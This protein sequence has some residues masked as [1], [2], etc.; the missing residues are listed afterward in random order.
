MKE[1]FTI[2]LLV[3]SQSSF[4]KLPDVI[5]YYY[6]SYL[7]ARDIFTV[8]HLINKKMKEKLKKIKLP[9]EWYPIAFNYH[10]SINCVHC[11]FGFFQLI[12]YSAILNLSLSLLFQELDNVDPNVL[13]QK[14]LNLQGKKNILL[15]IMNRTHSPSKI[16]YFNQ[17]RQNITEL[18]AQYKHKYLEIKEYNFYYLQLPDNDLPFFAQ[19]LIKNVTTLMPVEYFEILR[20]ILFYFKEKVIDKFLENSINSSKFISEKLRYLKIYFEILC[21]NTN[22][23]STINFIFDTYYS[24]SINLNQGKFNP[25]STSEKFDSFLEVYIPKIVNKLELGVII[26]NLDFLIACR[27]TICSLKKEEME[28]LI[29]KLLHHAIRNKRHAIFEFLLTIFT[30]PPEQFYLNKF[31][32]PLIERAINLRCYY[33]TM[34]IFTVVG[35]SNYQKFDNVSLL[36]CTQQQYIKSEDLIFPILFSILNI[37]MDTP[38]KNG[39]TLL[40]HVAISTQK[41]LY[42]IFKKNMTSSGLPGFLEKM[43]LLIILGADPKNFSQDEKLKSNSVTN[44]IE[45]IKYILFHS[46]SKCRDEKLRLSIN[47]TQEDRDNLKKI[48][49][50][51]HKPENPN[52]LLKSENNSSQSKIVTI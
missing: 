1:T 30:P 47:L 50:I 3:Y 13:F 46:N 18:E 34:R 20:K 6:L 48:S 51:A 21:Y 8:A 42:C 11:N 36:L 26:G 15:K 23:K 17:F 28:D 2:D 10:K 14:L 44:P 5:H 38:T 52:I 41:H 37:N 4:S 16:L 7:C 22:N 31:Y 35:I 45:A 27:D 24:F 40:E 25:N 49:F 29:L 32:Q 39:S 9:K 33:I 12:L 43:R 19:L